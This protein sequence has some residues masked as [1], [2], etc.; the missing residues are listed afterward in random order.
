MTTLTVE[1]WFDRREEMDENTAKKL[2]MFGDKV[3]I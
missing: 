2:S 1:S 3:C